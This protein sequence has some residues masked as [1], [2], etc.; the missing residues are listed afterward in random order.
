MY[1]FHCLVPCFIIHTNSENS[2][3]WLNLT[4]HK[5][6]THACSHSGEG[7]WR[8]A[9]QRHTDLSHDK[10]MTKNLMWALYASCQ[11]TFLVS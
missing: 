8:E 5:L 4:Q 1:T 7:S 3:P 10:F 9:P 6:C 2:Q 11:F